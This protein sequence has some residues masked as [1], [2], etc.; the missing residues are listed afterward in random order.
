MTGTS[1]CIEFVGRC[2]FQ[3]AYDHDDLLVSDLETYV[4]PV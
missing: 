2:S 3:D 1:L 4:A